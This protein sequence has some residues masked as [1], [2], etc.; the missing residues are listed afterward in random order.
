MEIR[1]K[2]HPGHTGKND[3]WLARRLSMLV[4]G[5]ERAFKKESGHQ[6]QLGE[7]N[8]W[9]MSRDEETGEVTVAYRYGHQR[10]KEME[11]LRIGIIFVMHLGE[12]NLPE[13]E[14]GALPSSSA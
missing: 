12:W 11:A 3:E 14:S 9:W 1:F 4:A 8:N 7:S 6:W 5:T 13:E 2:P 10:E